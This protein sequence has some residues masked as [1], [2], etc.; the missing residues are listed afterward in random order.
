MTMM[1]MI[2]IIMST[3]RDYVCELRPPAGL[4][5]ISQVV[6]NMENHGG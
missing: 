1:M 2:I 6:M 3:G 5:F 4:F